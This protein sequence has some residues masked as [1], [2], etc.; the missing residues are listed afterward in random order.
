LQCGGNLLDVISI[1]VKVCLGVCEIP[2][3][4]GLRYDLGQGV[5]V[6]ST[7]E[8]DFDYLDVSKAPIVVTL[9]RV[10]RF[11][12]VDASLE[13][14]SCSKGKLAFGVAPDGDVTSVD[15]LGRGCY[16]VKSLKSAS[17][18]GCSENL[19][20]MSTCVIQNEV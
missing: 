8:Y 9:P 12:V 10:G 13:E 15:K 7:D 4:T 17:E 19:Y 11:F 3:V 6:F 16:Q 1:A 18:V 14:E 2:R 20:A 5:P